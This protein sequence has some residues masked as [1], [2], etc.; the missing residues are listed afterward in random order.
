MSNA[1]PEQWIHNPAHELH[2]IYA[3]TVARRFPVFGTLPFMDS[4]PGL[5]TAFEAHK[6]GLPVEQTLLDIIVTPTSREKF[7]TELHDMVR[8]TGLD[9]W[10]E[11]FGSVA[12]VTNHEQFTDDPIVAETIG[13]MDLVE[14]EKIIMV[15]SKMISVMTL[16]LGEGEFTV[17]E[18]LRQISG[19]VKTVP[20]LDGTPSS[21]L[22]DFRR[23]SNDEAADVLSGAL[24]STGIVLVESFIGRHDQPSEDGKTLYIHEPNLNTARL[25]AAPNTKVVPIYVHCPTFTPDGGINTPDMTFK[26]FEPI[27]INPRRLRSASKH[28]VENFRQATQ[29]TLGDQYEA[30]RVKSWTQQRAERGKRK[31]TDA[32][33]HVPSVTTTNY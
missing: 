1:S 32:L 5:S 31:L 3:D 24:G 26:I 2:G 23:A 27:D 10:L 11:H 7:Q 30:V 14:R 20:R 19:L 22:A 9:D 28:I 17:T 29:A 13:R 12:F 33:S 18:K 25:L 15:I 4:Y 6:P 16:D 8:A 21:E